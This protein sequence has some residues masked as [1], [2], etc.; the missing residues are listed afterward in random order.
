MVTYKGVRGYYKIRIIYEGE[1]SGYA[2]IPKI[3]PTS[4]KYHFPA[5]LS[6]T[7]RNSRT[8]AWIYR[9]SRVIGCSLRGVGAVA[10][11]SGSC[12][13]GNKSLWKINYRLCRFKRRINSRGVAD[14]L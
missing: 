8:C 13:E 4:S 5:E 10:G 7:S 3:R 9:D 6:A 11:G 2:G 14:Y 12:P 1:R